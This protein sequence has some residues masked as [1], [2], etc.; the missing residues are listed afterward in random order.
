MGGCLTVDQEGDVPMARRSPAKGDGDGTSTEEPVQRQPQGRSVESDG[1]PE[2][3]PEQIAEKRVKQLAEARAKRRKELEDKRRRE[4]EEERAMANTKVFG[5]PVKVSAVRS[6]HERQLSPA[7]VSV[8]MGWIREHGLD[9]EGLFRIPG[10]LEKVKQYK[11]QFD[12]GDYNIV[13]SPNENV[14]NVASIVI[15]F[16]NELDPKV[17]NET[18]LYSDDSKDWHKKANTITK[19]AKKGAPPPTKAEIV[20]KQKELL[21]S[22]DPAAAEVFRQIVV[23]LKEASEAEHATNNKMDPKKFSLCTFPAIMVF[24]EELILNYDDVFP[25]Q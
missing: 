23:V 20:K 13:I 9:A 18:D 4:E 17:F 5:V 19:P 15:R 24:V 14:E 22:L 8:C 21:L 1:E 11:R 25:L 16:L 7:P 6:D 3:T 2:E 12:M 10:S